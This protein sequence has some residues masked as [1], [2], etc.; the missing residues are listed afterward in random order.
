MAKLFNPEEPN[1]LQ[2]TTVM[3]NLY[4]QLNCHVP[5][6]KSAKPPVATTDMKKGLYLLSL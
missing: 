5:A 2:I 1:I 6:S 3:V 4:Q